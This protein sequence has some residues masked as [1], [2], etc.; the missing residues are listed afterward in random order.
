[1]SDQFSAIMMMIGGAVNTGR[2]N[3]HRK[4]NE[5]LLCNGFS[6][7]SR[8]VQFSFGSSVERVV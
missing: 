8:G 2:V 5:G 1:M 3:G 7:V 6:I 4:Y